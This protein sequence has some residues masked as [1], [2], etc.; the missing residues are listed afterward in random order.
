MIKASLTIG[1]S[2][3]LVLI[4]LSREN[5]TF[6][7]DGKPIHVSTEAFGVPNGPEIMLFARETE[8]DLVNELSL[9]VSVE[10]VIEDQRE[11]GDG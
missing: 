9:Y 4:G 8:E 11:G 10:K 5:T 6:L 3:K 7:H 2:R 1:N